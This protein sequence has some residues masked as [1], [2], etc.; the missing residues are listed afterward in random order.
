[1]VPYALA[2]L[3][4]AV[5]ILFLKLASDHKSILDASVRGAIV[6]RVQSLRADQPAAWGKMNA[7]E[8]LKHLRGAMEMATGALDIPDSPRRFL[9][10]F[11]LKQLI[12]FILPF[13]KGAPTAPQLVT[14]GAAIDFEAEKAAVVA[15]IGSFHEASPQPWPEH[16]AFG[17][18]GREGWGTLAWK[19]ADHHLKQFG[20]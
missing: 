9:R 15:L 17:E 14:T 6:A 13:P 7:G 20:A 1:M 8:M 18:L 4:L 2:A 11:P 3:A 16:P 19:H 5:A 10:V 12:V